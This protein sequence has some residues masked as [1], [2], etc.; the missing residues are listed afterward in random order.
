MGVHLPL[1]V[2]SA[3]ACRYRG[4]GHAGFDVAGIENRSLHPG[5]IFVLETDAQ[6]SSLILSLLIKNFLW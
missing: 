1:K 2:L 5:D 3:A 6:Q 4:Q